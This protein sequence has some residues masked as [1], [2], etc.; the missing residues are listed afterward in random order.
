MNPPT[1]I[2]LRAY[3]AAHQPA[4]DCD[5]DSIA[6]GLA[7]ELAGWERP[8]PCTAMQQFLWE[9][10]WRA[11]ASVLRADAM[12]AALNATEIKAAADTSPL[13]K[14]WCEAWAAKR[15]E[16]RAQVAEAALAD[17][18]EV[19]S[20]LREYTS[21]LHYA[22]TRLPEKENAEFWIRVKNGQP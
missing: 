14:A 22:S 13:F 20:G 10:S 21:K 19:E 12:I 3:I 2:T 7:N 17:S 18:K 5:F 16:T 1:T 4:S 15:A 6:T 8:S 11:K 9:C